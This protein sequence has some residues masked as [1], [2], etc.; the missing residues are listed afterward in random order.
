MVSSD[1]IRH[2]IFDDS[3]YKQPSL[4]KD[5]LGNMKK[6]SKWRCFIVLNVVVTQSL[7][8]LSACYIIFIPI[9]ISINV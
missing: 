7:S 4:Y 3:F 1:K 2:K 8:A 5:D 9:E 6:V